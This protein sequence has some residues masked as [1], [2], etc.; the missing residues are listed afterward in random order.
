LKA[1]KL[2][3]GALLVVALLAPQAN[4]IGVMGSWWDQDALGNGYGL[5]LIHKFG[6]IPLISIDVRA[7]WLSFTDELIEANVFPLEATGRA[8]LGMFY[9]GLGLGYYIFS[10]KDNVDLDN[11]IGGYI[12]GGVDIGL[13][14]FGVFG[15]LKYTITDKN[16]AD[17]IGANIGVN[18]GL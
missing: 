5:G 6:I 12:L 16:S 10:G 17:G 2:V 3:I 14:G 1:R 7:S 9:G 15:E 13:A 11:T 18:F 4:A 8:N